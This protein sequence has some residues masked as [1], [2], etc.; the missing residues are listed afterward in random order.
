L[1][2]YDIVSWY[3]T[4]LTS[5]L[6]YYGA[7]LAFYMYVVHDTSYDIPIV[8]SLMVGGRYNSDCNRKITLGTQPATLEGTP[9]AYLMFIDEKQ[10]RYYKRPRSP[11]RVKKTQKHKNTLLVGSQNPTCNSQCMDRNSQCMNR[12]ANLSVQELV[13]Y[14]TNSRNSLNYSI[15]MCR[16]ACMRV[17]SLTTRCMHSCIHEPWVCASFLCTL[18][19][20]CI[21]T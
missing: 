17:V 12:K 2:S 3:D 11:V 9:M 18:V 20:R 4:T 5:L 6:I 7:T 1:T 8:N 21:C 15:C 16:H 10:T 19:L 13:D 14:K